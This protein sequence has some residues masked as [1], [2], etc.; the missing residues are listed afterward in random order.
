VLVLCGVIVL[1]GLIRGIPFF[2]MLEIG[3]SLAIAA[4]P[5]GLTAV[6]TMTLALGMQRMVGMKALVRRLPAVETLGSTT[7][8]CTDKT[9]TLTRNE[10]TVRAFDLSG[11]AIEVT[12]TGYE[13][14]GSF[15]ENGRTINQPMDEHLRLALR[16]GALCNDAA[17]ESRD[18][19]VAVLGDPTEGALLVAARKE[20]LS[21]DER[22]RGYKRTR[23]VP[24]DSASKRMITIH[25]DPRGGEIAYAKGAVSAILELCSSVYHDTEILLLSETARTQIRL[26][27]EALASRALRVLALAYRELPHPI[28]DH[29]LHHDFVFVGLVGMIDPLREEVKEAVKTCRGAGIRVIMLTGDQQATAA[30]IAR[31]LE[32]NR[33]P[34][35]AERTIVHARE[36]ENL[37]DH[38]WRDAARRAAVFA[39][40]SP[41]HKLRIVEGLQRDGQ[42]VAMTGDG[43]ND[44][45]AL[46]KADI[47]IAMGIKGTEVAKEAADLV[48][49]DDNFATIVRA[50][51]EGRAIYAN[52]RKVIHYLFSCNASEILV[53]FTA[54]M[55]GWPAPLSALQIL[56]LNLIT[57]VFP[58]LSLAMEPA[59][60]HVMKQP[61]RHP[62][63]PLLDRGFSGL[64]AWQ[65]ALL[66][67]A[68]LVAFASGLNRHGAERPGLQAAST[69]AFTT[70]A[71]AQI[72]HVFNTRSR[73][74]S[75]FTAGFF[76]NPWLWAAV[77]VCIGLQVAASLQPLL[78]SVLRTVPLDARDWT[79]IAIA[80]LAPTAFVEL[81]KAFGRARSVATGTT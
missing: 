18:G 10:M 78:R 15:L 68:T 1:A 79:L 50:V 54:I 16:I 25:E 12:G 22:K 55:I 5:E 72:V 37:D 56:W 27:N 74:R 44:A 35:G 2:E 61:P 23:E 40:V 53:V 71:L 20:G 47:G 58:A 9:G 70:L 32:L 34:V 7:V 26:A 19:E 57:D 51:E 11:R 24:F 43:V 13:A 45:P 59:A 64:L 65:G 39:R 66:A 52:I 49:T 38:G 4:V 62:G 28:A 14:A 60:P 3:I 42:I 21:P 69:I 77:A 33:D 41:E 31:K 80:S 17:I 36:L 76:A 6:A 81:A 63:K 30:E 29:E 46:K 73:T 75:T 67:V 48:I 8:I